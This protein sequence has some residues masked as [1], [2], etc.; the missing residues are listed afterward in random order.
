LHDL[1]SLVHRANAKIKLNANVL[2]KY[3]TSSALSTIK[4]TA[5]GVEKARR[6]FWRRE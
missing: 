4:T 1:Y 3:N 5:E 6:T 2:T